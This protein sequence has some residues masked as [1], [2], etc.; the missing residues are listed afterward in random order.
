[1][2]MTQYQSVITRCGNK[3]KYDK[4]ELGT[5]L[6]YKFK[7]GIRFWSLHSGQVSSSAPGSWH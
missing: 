1:L 4:V 5:A 2:F 6:F 7:M 3:D